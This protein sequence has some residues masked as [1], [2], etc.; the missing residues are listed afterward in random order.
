MLLSEN[1]VSKV[2]MTI[3]N[4][5]VILDPFS[6]SLFGDT[7]F[8]HDWVVCFNGYSV[9]VLYHTTSSYLSGEETNSSDD[10]D[11]EMPTSSSSHL[12]TMMYSAMSL[13][14]HLQE[15]NQYE[16]ALKVLLTS[17]GSCL[18]HF[19]ANTTS[20]DLLCDK[21]GDLTFCLI[22][23][24]VIAPDARFASGFTFYHFSKHKT[25]LYRFMQ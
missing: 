13:L 24:G 9:I 21:V 2:T 23:K 11:Q 6:D 7:V 19:V 15:N 25:V 20:L 16:I 1:I 10:A 22:L 3:L 12:D 17:L 18:Q 4:G 5:L 8:F 14:Q